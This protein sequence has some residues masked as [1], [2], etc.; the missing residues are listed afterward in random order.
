LRD[1]PDDLVPA[2]TFVIARWIW[3]TV[4]ESP[5]P[6]H[7][8]FDE[9]GALSEHAAL[10][11]LL[12]Q[13]ARRCRKY[14][15]GLVVATQNVEDMIRTPEGGVV[16]TNCATVLLGGHRAAETS[17]MAA[18]FGL[19]EKQKLSLDA[20]P[21]G[22]FLLTSGASRLEIDVAGP[23]LYRDVI[24]GAATSLAFMEPGPRPGR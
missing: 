8:I 6:R 16:A 12:V 23:P 18:V 14:G 7:V 20:A 9:V 10:R 4:T 5:A 2:L 11:T 15:A 22:R 13:L 21:R 17:R 1:I 19:S 24:T 3:Q